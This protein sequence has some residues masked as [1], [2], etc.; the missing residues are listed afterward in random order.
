MKLI[1]RSVK[2]IRIDGEMLRTKFLVS[3]DENLYLDVVLMY[4]DKI[5]DT[6]STTGELKIKIEC[7]K[8]LNRKKA[9]ELRIYIPKGIS[10]ENISIDN[11]MS[12]IYME[13]IQAKQLQIRV[14]M[15]TVAIVDA[16]VKQLR[17]DTKMGDFDYLG[18]ITER[19][20]V[21]NNKGDIVMNLD[22]IEAEVGYYVK[23]SLGDLI[24]GENKHSGFIGLLEGNKNAPVFLDLRTSM[25]DIK[26]FFKK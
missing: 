14:E 19:A 12:D 17:V 3:K 15:S 25:G 8:K 11:N 9:S 7:S 1:S 22:N 21:M 23:N 24:V 20:E 10:F 16:T 5:F 2:S 26:I 6:L 18:I 4:D 13:S